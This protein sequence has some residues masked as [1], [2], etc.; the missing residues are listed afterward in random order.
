MSRTSR[1]DADFEP[2]SAEI[3][4][5]RQRPDAVNERASTDPQEVADHA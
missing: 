1:D 5:S 4:G 2:V 3:A